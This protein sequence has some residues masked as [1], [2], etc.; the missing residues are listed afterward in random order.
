M[1]QLRTTNLR[2][3]LGGFCAALAALLL[4][5]PDHFG[6]P[7]YAFLQ[8]ALRLW[9]ITFLLAAVALLAVAALRLRRPIATTA[10]L[11]A[12]VLLLFLA[13]SFGVGGF[14]TGTVNYGIL[15]IGLALAPLVPAP[16]ASARGDQRGDLF[17]AL[18]GIGA[19][20]T[21]ALLV[22]FPG[23]LAAPAYDQ[24]RPYFP[25]YAAAFLVGGVLLVASQLRG[26]LPRPVSLLGHLVTSGALFASLFTF[27]IPA[28]L[29][30]AAIFYGGFG[31]AL[32]IVPVVERWLDEIDPGSLRTHL[33]L[34]L[35][36]T[37]ALA[38]IAGV[39][40]GSDAV[41]SGQSGRDL[42][43]EILALFVGIAVVAGAL[44]SRQLTAPLH[45]L[46][47]AVE[48]LTAGDDTA[49]LPR[50]GVS[51]IARLTDDFAELR[52]R[53]IARTDE[54][55]RAEDALRQANESLSER[56][57]ELERRDHEIVL[58][59]EIGEL[60][61][62]CHTRDD[63][64]QVMIHGGKRLF[65][66]DS[67]A[68]C[69]LRDSQNLVEAVV[70]WGDGLTGEPAF[71]PD[72]CWAL[73]RGQIHRL[74]DVE[75]GLLCRHLIRDST[76]SYVCVPMLAQGQ[77]LG[78]FHVRSRRVGP[79]HE[80]AIEARQQLAMAVAE[81]FALAVT[82]LKLEEKLQHQ[83]VRDPLTGLFNRRYLEETFDREISRASRGERP[84]GVIMLDLDHFKRVN[85]TIGHTAGD[86]LLRE[87]GRFLLANV[88]DED[89]AC[90]YGGEE[91]TL[92]LPDATLRHTARRAEQ[93][94]EGIR[95]LHVSHRGR[96]VGP[97]TAS[98]GI[99][100]YPEH[101]ATSEALIR[102]AD[103]AL[104]RAKEAGRDRCE[105]ADPHQ[106]IEV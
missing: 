77:A 103:V 58:L 66:D 6:S 104:Y 60:L 30:T 106:A 15:G 96:T 28:G 32:A 41:S 92:I 26:S 69:L 50:S 39:I 97:L 29:W 48:R 67:G 65:P 46:E 70:V 16:D 38:L 31:V 80:R 94:C 88:R 36:A 83:A 23:Q 11:F 14:W 3:A 21:S 37:A 27:A 102:A 8:P 90:R 22:L 101:G 42:S 105:I 73:R 7:I 72:D 81:H 62:T 43:F 10:H 19:I 76:A 99:A 64:Y 78:I 85:D 84:I 93:L 95:H 25:L 18:A 61:Q 20:V 53:L 33:A 13:Y 44:V 35:V 57:G 40:L 98:C 91:F 86:E 34:I 9:G 63:L 24:I 51:E 54:R 4:I 68:I 12:S 45:A 79:G 74:D 1:W 52:D 59:S 5:T 89:V 2:W 47:R 49:P 75:T 71:A 56:V 55:G 100:A 82:N 87:L 17:A